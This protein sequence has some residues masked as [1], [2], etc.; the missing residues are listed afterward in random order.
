MSGAIPI[1]M[2]LEGSKDLGWLP[3][4]IEDRGNISYCS[5]T[6]HHPDSSSAPLDCLL[7]LFLE[8][9]KEENPLL[10]PG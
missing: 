8:E 1:E 7:L 6:H 4:W 10:D 3:G 9:Q 5:D 2:D